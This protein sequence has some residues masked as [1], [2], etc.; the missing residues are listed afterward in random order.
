MSYS[1]TYDI[2]TPESAAHGD[3]AESG[4]ISR[5]VPLREALANLWQTRTRYVDG[6]H[7]IESDC[8]EPARASSVRVING[9]EFESGAVESRSIHFPDNLTSASR[10][11]LCRAIRLGL[12]S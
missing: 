9:T 10:A 2:T 7:A 1:V 3:H 11:R 8:S 4:F 5:D 6:V 12:G